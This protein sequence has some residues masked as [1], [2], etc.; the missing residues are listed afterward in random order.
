MNAVVERILQHPLRVAIHGFAD[1]GVAGGDVL[2]IRR[3][4]DGAGKVQLEPVVRAAVVGDAEDG[5]NRLVAIHHQIERI[6]VAAGAAAPAEE[7]IPWIGRGT[8]LNIGVE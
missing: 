1:I 8:K 2:Q 3:V 5:I 7:A 6:R 4:G